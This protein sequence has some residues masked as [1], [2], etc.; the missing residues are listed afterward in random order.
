MNLFW[1]R[2]DLRLE[3]NAGLY[4]ALK[5]GKPVQCL[6]IFDAGI[7]NRLENKKDARVEFIHNCILK[8]NAD[9]KKYGSSLLVKHGKPLDVFKELNE[10][11]GIDSVYTNHDYEPYATSRD[12]E[13]KD[14]LYSFGISF[15]TYKDQVI[16]EKDEI[17]S[18]TGTTYTVFTPYSK[19]WKEKLNA[20]YLS[21]YPVEKYI[22]N[23]SRIEN[24]EIPS[25]E[26]L[27]F[28][29]TDTRIPAIDISENLLEKYGETRNALA[30]D[31]TSHAGVYLRFGVISVRFLV[32]KAN[33]SGSVFLNELIWREFFQMILW[34]FPNVV[35][36]SF[37][38]QYDRIE[39]RNNESE[40]EAWC[41]GRTGY[42][43]VDA[44]M[45]EL[46]AT[47]FMHNRA[48]MI[49]ASFLC[50]HLL[51]DWR[52][53]EQYFAGK[54]LDYELASNN[55]NWQWAAGTGCDAAPYF[56]IFS[57]DAQQ[58]RFDPLATYILRWVP[59]YGTP[60]YPKPIVVHEFARQRALAEYK[61]ALN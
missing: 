40:F 25:L 1:F 58:K 42:P 8:L 7:L 37:R 19:K 59:E 23:L 44:G 60:A 3:D 11:L 34:H 21:S 17:L 31:A 4:H 6:F 51:I 33:S 35:E 43:V 30:L 61:R 10:E 47:G 24:H 39:W 41:Q 56:R 18:N 16:F 12:K 45:R 49:V 22:T 53:G 15:H 52:W 29:A 26:E 5:E 28:S 48:R 50:K 9:L 27:G 54:L 32:R 55:G 38:R 57:P 14:Y 13:I 36:H 20:F 46:N 2:R